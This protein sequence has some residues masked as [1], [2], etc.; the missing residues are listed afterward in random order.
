MADLQGRL[1]RVKAGV[2]KK[3][4]YEQINQPKTVAEGPVVRRGDWGMYVTPESA[5]NCL[6][7]EL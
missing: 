5:M 3:V 4:T 6:I 1:D 2:S 7:S